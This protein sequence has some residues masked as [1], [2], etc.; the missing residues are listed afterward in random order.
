MRL[1]CR[2]GLHDWSPY[3]YIESIDI[4]GD[5]FGGMT[6]YPTS[7]KR[8]YERHCTSCGQPHVKRI[9]Q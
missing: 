7:T 2:V 4:Y 9:K 1:V 6:K 8:V 5:G 3:K